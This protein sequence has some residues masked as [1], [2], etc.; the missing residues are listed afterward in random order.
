MSKDKAEDDAKKIV[1]EG[2]ER[3]KRSDAR[4]QKPEK[5]GDSGTCSRICGGTWRT[6]RIQKRDEYGEVESR[7][8]PFV[9]PSAHAWRLSDLGSDCLFVVV[10][11]WGPFWLV[12]STGVV[13][14]TT[15]NL[16]VVLNYM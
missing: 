2:T 12:L 15:C 14:P 1:R 9:Q 5:P 8:V 6:T 4:R 16:L 11:F 13:A 3:T 7:I 10:L